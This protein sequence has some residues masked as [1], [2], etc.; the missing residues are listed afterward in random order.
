MKGPQMKTVMITGAGSGLG[1]ATALTLAAQ[2]HTVYA[3][4]Q[5]RPQITDLLRDGEALDDRLRPFRL[6]LT[7]DDTLGVDR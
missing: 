3:G 7:R 5:I 2:G 6:D 1:R 4:C